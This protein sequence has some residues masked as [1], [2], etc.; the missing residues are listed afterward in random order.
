MHIYYIYNIDLFLDEQLTLNITD[1]VFY[2][3][4]KQLN[5]VILQFSPEVNGLHRMQN[6]ESVTFCN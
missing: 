6:T 5:S 3:L 4:S 2:F 1:S